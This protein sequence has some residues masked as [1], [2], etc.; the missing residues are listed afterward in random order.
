[1]PRGDLLEGN[2]FVRC[3]QIIFK[4]RYPECVVLKAN[5][6]INNDPG[7]VDMAKGDFRMKRGKDT[8][9]K[10]FEPIPFDKIGLNPNNKETK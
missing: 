3:G 10:G 5:R 7:F 2:L 8:G 1:M 6:E 9:I 4:N